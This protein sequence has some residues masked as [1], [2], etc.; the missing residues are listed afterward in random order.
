M[1]DGPE[2]DV[3]RLQERADQEERFAA[4]GRVAVQ[5]GLA[6]AGDEAVGHH[7]LP[8]AGGQVVEA[9][10]PGVV[11][12]MPLA[13]VGGFVAGVAEP[14]PQVGAAGVNGPAVV[15]HARLHR[16][17]PGKQR[18][19]RR[20]AD[21]I[22]AMRLLKG[23]AAGDEP[24]QIGRAGIGAAVGRDGVEA[25][26]IGDQQQEIGRPRR[27]HG[28]GGPRPPRQPRH[29]GR[30][31]RAG[32][33]KLPAIFSSGCHGMLLPARNQFLPS[34]LAGEGSGVRGLLCIVDYRITTYQR[35]ST[36]R[37]QSQTPP[38]ALVRAHRPSRPTARCRR[39]GDGTRAAA[40]C[41]RRPYPRR[42]W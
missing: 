7:A 3:V 8:A 15:D 37:L 25:Q 1:L 28:G 10:H 4:L 16:H 29:A 12:Q 17:P 24:I 18:A 33:Q 32:L 42:C 27:G 35:Y 21:R 23:H 39:P 22:A 6:G 31:R 40:P 11:G 19:P 9:R 2:A 34:P 36:H 41:G 30:R 26:L 13:A 20:R 5:I 38:A 14:L